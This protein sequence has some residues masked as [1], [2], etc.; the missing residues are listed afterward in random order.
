M[1]KT[2]QDAANELYPLDTSREDKRDMLSMQHGAFL[3][4][5][6]WHA[7]QE[8]WI[9]VENTDELPPRGESVLVYDDNY[10]VQIGWLNISGL[11]ELTRKFTEPCRITHWQ[12]L[13]EP[14]KM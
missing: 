11:W 10:G 13:P 14:P 12:P 3:A 7:E 4:G 2:A 1:S 5:A 8:G 9:S 6:A